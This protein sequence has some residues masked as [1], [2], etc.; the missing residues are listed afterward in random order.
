MKLWKLTA[1]MRGY[2]T[3]DSAIVAAEDVEAAR[4]IH[5]YGG[6]YPCED[7]DYE[8]GSWAFKPAA[9]SA[10]LIGT[11]TEG[12]PAGVVLASFNAG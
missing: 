7:W 9:V 3:F 11:A 5:P 12:T 4:S 1:G 8:S 10:V 6:F 2:D